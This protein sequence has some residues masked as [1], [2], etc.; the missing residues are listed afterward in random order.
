MFLPT[1]PSAR[2][3]E[4]FIEQSRK[5]RLSYNQVG[6]AKH[7][8]A[9]FKIDEAK[10][11]IGRGASAFAR[12]RMALQ[13][14]RHCKLGWVSVFPENASI[15]TGTTIVVVVRHLGFWSLNGCRVVYGL[16]AAAGDNQFGFAYGTLPN[17]AEMGEEIFEVSML[18]GSEEVCYRIRAAS[19]PRAVLAKIGYPLTRIL[20]A[21]FRRDSIRA[22]QRALNAA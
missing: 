15:E 10:L 13:E 18:P 2:Q 3:L 14:W 4:D 21:R 9:D 7:S 5:L 12:A 6:V 20:Q 8:S 16:D 22:M 17:H 1:R 19:K 11:V